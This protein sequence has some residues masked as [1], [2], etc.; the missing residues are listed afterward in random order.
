LARINVIVD[1][2]AGFPEEYSPE[3]KKLDVISDLV[4]AYENIHYSID[5]PIDG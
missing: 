4:I 1:A 3:Y 5:D 2:Q